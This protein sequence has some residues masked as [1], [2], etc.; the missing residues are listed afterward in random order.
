MFDLKRPCNNCPFRK[1]MGER[2]QLAPERLHEIFDAPAFQCHKTLDTSAED[3][4]PERK[5]DHPQQCAGLM[6]L[7]H[8][9]GRDNQITQ[10][11]TRLSDFDPANLEHSSVYDSID[12]CLR[13]HAA[14]KKPG[15]PLR[16]VVR[17]LGRSA[18]KLKVE[19][20]CGHEALT[21]STYKVRCWECANDH[22]PLFAPRPDR[23]QRPTSAPPRRKLAEMPNVRARARAPSSAK[24]RAVIAAFNKVMH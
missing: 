13:A 22:G 12:D 4:T 3:G 2:F 8:R 15:V 23:P 21:E 6:S 24:A 7:L 16:K 18:G 11:A 20:E 9:A 19:L 1:G 5:G 17:T 10:V 14:T